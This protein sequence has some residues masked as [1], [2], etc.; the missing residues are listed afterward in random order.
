MLHAGIDPGLR[1]GLAVLE[2]SGQVVAVVPIPTTL[3]DTGREQYDLPACRGLFA[4]FPRVELSV[5]VE[6]LQPL[7]SVFNRKDGVK[8]QSG[9]IAN[10]NRGLSHGWA[11]LL[12]G[13]GIPYE[14]VPPQTWQ[15]VML[16]GI[17]GTDTKARS[18]LAAKNLWPRVSLLRSDR[19]R[20]ESDGLSD[21]LLLAEYGRR[22]RMG[23]E[24]FAA[25]ARA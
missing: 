3:S 22:Q 15:R 13:L 9:G 14:L 17:P 2:D 8:Q 10:F 1:G 7:P 25:A 16:Q 23:G 12:T 6:K 5:M 20:V 18:I 11:W 21:A 24:V 19:S 4:G